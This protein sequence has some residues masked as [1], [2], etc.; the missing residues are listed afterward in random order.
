[1]LDVDRNARLRDGVPGPGRYPGPG[2]GPQGLSQLILFEG[3][4][5]AHRQGTGTAQARK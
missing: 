5:A 4:E 3:A 1:M 2:H